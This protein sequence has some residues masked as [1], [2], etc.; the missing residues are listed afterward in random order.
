MKSLAIVVLLTFSTAPV[1]FGQ[2]QSYY[3]FTLQNAAEISYQVWTNIEIQP[4]GRLT[5]TAEA[6]ANIISRTLVSSDGTPWLG[7][8]V[9]IDRLNDSDFHVWFAAIPGF[10]FFMEA[11]TPRQVHDGDRVLLDVLEQPGTGKKVFDTLEIHSKHAPHATL[12]L[13][14]KSIPGIVA[15]HTLLRMGHARLAYEGYDALPI[16][17]DATVTSGKSVFVEVPSVGRFTL[18]SEPGPGYLLDAICEGSTVHFVVDDDTYILSLDGPL[19]AASGAWY[20]WV[21]F[22]HFNNDGAALQSLNRG[23]PPIRVEIAR[24]AS[25]TD[26]VR[27]PLVI[28]IENTSTR[29]ILAYTIK[30]QLTDSGTGK[31][32][33]R[34]H[35]V[36]RMTSDRTPN[37]LHP[38]ETADDKIQITRTSSGSRSDVRATADL[39]I[40]DDGSAW[41]PM[42]ESSSKQQ[43]KA[44][45]NSE[46][47]RTKLL[48]Q[49]EKGASEN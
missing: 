13:P 15:E 35:Q 33:E 39:V 49:A 6:S 18:S 25:G 48:S 28:E 22:D 47:Y 9:H 36:L 1:A 4:Q 43:L 31:Q 19:I 32:R 37:Y 26:T 14:L 24:L 41:G 46:Y 5:S 20:V 16:T 12:P 30:I 34:I 23:I 11:P 2:E 40:F 27:S 29:N 21:H 45:K 8:E 7:F 44:I 10:P 42:S 3:E 38:G 17:Q